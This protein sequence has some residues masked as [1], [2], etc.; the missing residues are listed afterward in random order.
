MSHHQ[1]LRIKGKKMTRKIS[2]QSETYPINDIDEYLWN[3]RLGISTQLP[4]T[5]PSQNQQSTSSLPPQPSQA[6]DLEYDASLSQSDMFGSG[7]SGGNQMIAPKP[8]DTTPASVPAVSKAA[9]NFMNGNNSL[10]GKTSAVSTLY[11]DVSPTPTTGESGGSQA[12][13]N[14][15]S[16]NLPEGPESNSVSNIAPEEEGGAGLASDLGE[17][18]SLAAFA[19]KHWIGSVLDPKESKKDDEKGHYK[20]I[21]HRNGKWVIIQKGTGKV[22][23]T[24]DSR[25]KAIESF[26]A[27]EMSKHG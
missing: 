23:S 6:P 4:Q 3:K 26:K 18:A 5:M 21:K 19:N 27:M 13:P 22:L 16:S 10:S 17:A 25:E 24:H 12:N 1:N 14:D 15:S 7:I 2:R 11:G 9:K 8:I 20:Y